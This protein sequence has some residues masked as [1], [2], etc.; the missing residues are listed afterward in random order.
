FHDGVYLIFLLGLLE[1]FF[2][3]LYQY[4]IT[5][6]N[7]DQKVCCTEDRLVNNQGNPLNFLLFCLFVSLFFADV[8]QKDLKSTLR[9]LYSLFQKYK[10]MK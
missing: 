4:Y 10:N 2:V 6:A 3:P 1:G 5:P 8:V 9:I 7:K